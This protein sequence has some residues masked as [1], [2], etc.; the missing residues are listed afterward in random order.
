MQTQQRYVLASSLSHTHTHTHTLS[1]SLSLSLSLPALYPVCFCLFFCLFQA[2]V[3]ERN[4]S[5]VIEID[6]EEQ[7]TLR[8]TPPPEQKD[9]RNFCLS[10]AL[11]T[12]THTIK[13]LPSFHSQLCPCLQG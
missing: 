5:V 8:A 12:R 13:L 6:A 3:M 1:L 4:N 2:D 7:D 11:H 10:L 9:V